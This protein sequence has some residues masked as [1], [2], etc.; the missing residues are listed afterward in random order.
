MRLNS[1]PRAVGN[2]KPESRGAKLGPKF[3]LLAAAA[4]FVAGLITWIWLSLTLYTP[5]GFVKDYLSAL[6]A[7]EVSQVLAL[8]GQNPA[9]GP[10]ISQQALG[11]LYSAEVTG[12]VERAGERWE[13]TAEYRFEEQ[14]E[15]HSTTFIVAPAEK[16]LGLFQEWR[17]A[18]APV[19]KLTLSVDRD[20][21]L[22]VNATSVETVPLTV[23]SEREFQ[24]LI[25]GRYALQHNSTYLG[26]ETV[27]LDLSST[28][29]VAIALSTEATEA[30]R[31]LVQQQVEAHLFS[32]A[33]QTIN[34]PEGCP[35]G[36][37]FSDRVLD[38]PHWALDGTPT[39][40]LTPSDYGW[41]ASGSGGNVHLS[42]TLLS[43]ATGQQYP[44]NDSFRFGVR[45]TVELT[46]AGNL[47]LT[48]SL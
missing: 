37:H 5:A 10:L 35:F 38:G 45:Y 34:F 24:V 18:E 8:Q 26:S 15:L 16:W 32:C 6:S 2:S 33:E 17:F 11:D 7:K 12:V 9:S 40:E 30:L 39:I 43:I 25:P 46:T 13:V 48:P 3:W 47:V 20:W 19:A 14:G 23:G 4:S 41:I 28:E 22:D 29:S 31:T 1:A 21:R 44:F 42:A 36:F 27:V